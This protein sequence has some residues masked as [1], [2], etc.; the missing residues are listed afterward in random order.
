MSGSIV[1]VLR[2]AA[3]LFK[4]AG[5]EWSNDNAPRLGASLSYY[6]IFSMAPVLLLVIAVAGLALGEKAAQGRSSTSCLA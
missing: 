6:T 5:A 3:R 4:T 2:K 1:N